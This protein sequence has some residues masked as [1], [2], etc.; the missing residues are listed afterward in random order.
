MSGRPHSAPPLALLPHLRRARDLADR[1]YADPLDL[2]ELA[3]AA[4]VS[5]YHFLRAFAAVY[6]LTPAAY[7]TERRIE[8]AQDLLRATNL[9]VTEVCMLVGYSSLGSFSSKFRKLVGVTPSEYQ[10]K[11]A[12]GAPRIPGCFVF[13]HGLSDRTRET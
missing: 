4:G 9:T 11:F 12:D 2:D 7:L 13:M 3:A 1:R 6:G 10:A 8:R 5:K